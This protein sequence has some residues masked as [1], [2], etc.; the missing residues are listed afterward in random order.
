MKALVATDLITYRTPY[1][2]RPSLV[3]RLLLTH[4][5]HNRDNPRSWE[6]FKKSFHLLCS[7]QY[8]VTLT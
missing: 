1:H 5:C 2:E 6:Y 3:Y 7:L 8:F 4:M